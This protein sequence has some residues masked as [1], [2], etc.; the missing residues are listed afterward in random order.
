[1]THCKYSGPRRVYIIPEPKR[2][3]H[4]KRQLHISVHNF[5]KLQHILA[6]TIQV[7][8]Q[9]LEA[10]IICQVISFLRT[11]LCNYIEERK[12]TAYIIVQCIVTREPLNH[13]VQGSTEITRF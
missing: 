11:L 2:L 12:L 9:L 4:P 3:L 6:S 10:F 13:D 5:A 8:F 1:M 7:A